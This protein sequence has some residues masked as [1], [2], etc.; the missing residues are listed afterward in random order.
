M[1][2]RELVI[3]RDKVIRGMNTLMDGAG[4][5]KSLTAWEKNQYDDLNIQLSQI[6]KKLN[7]PESRQTLP[8][9]GGN[10]M[11]ESST[12]PFETMGE[13]L[14]AIRNAA[15]PGQRVDN[16]LHEV[17]AAT[18]LSESVPS[19]GGFLLQPEFSNQILK[20]AWNTGD[21]LSRVRR[22]PISRSSLK[23]PAVDETS[24]ATGSRH[25]GVRGFWV[26]EASEKTASAPQ[27][28]QIEMNLR[29]LC[30]LVYATDEL[31]EDAGA[32]A[33][34]V[35]TAAEDEIRF[36]TEDA[37]INGTGSGTPLGILNAGATVTQDKEGS[38]VAATL[39]YE[40]LI[41]MWQR[42]PQANRKNAI[43][44]CE[45]S[46]ESQL[47]SMYLSVSNYGGAGV[48]LPGGSI[49][50]QPYNTILGR[51]LIPVEYCQDLGTEGDIIFADLS[52]YILAE[53]AGGISSDMSIHVEF[54]TD[55]SVFR[56]VFRVDGQPM[57]AAPI[58]PYSAGS[59]LSPFVTLQ[60]RS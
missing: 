43:W 28:R 12:G 34:H 6:N 29:K 1:N 44:L 40:N 59:T 21:I 14:Q 8:G 37:I 35:Q 27:F 25:G 9:A 39:V 31:L 51:P 58:T 11:S 32:L 33:S 49:A 45:Q 26:D 18:G 24:R 41:K 55:Q 4:S 5:Y 54:K 10:M 15:I 56:F 47:M 20:N 17:R 38:Q 48:F 2:V 60:T 13:Q 7:E 23:I 42:M 16:R 22:M 3:K 30:V 53:R 36:M 57:L 46:V 19:D 50:T 52:Q